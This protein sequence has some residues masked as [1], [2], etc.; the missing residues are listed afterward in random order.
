MG[1]DLNGARSNTQDGDGWGS[2]EGTY[3]EDGL[4]TYD[5]DGLGTYDGDGLGTY[6]NEDGL[7]GP[8]DGPH[9][10]Y[11]SGDETGDARP[12]VFVSSKRWLARSLRGVELVAVRGD[13]QTKGV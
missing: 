5:E 10:V 13:E 4:G 9:A 6:D 7:L 3:D 1:S 12:G 11:L 8:A 2:Y